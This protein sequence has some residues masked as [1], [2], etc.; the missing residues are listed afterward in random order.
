[1]PPCVRGR[2]G[3]PWDPGLGHLRHGRASL[4]RFAL[5]CFLCE[6]GGSGGISG[7][8]VPGCGGNGLE[9][10]APLPLSRSAPAAFLAQGIV[11]WM[12]IQAEKLQATYSKGR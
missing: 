3:S 10:P 4:Q 7:F 9:S 12:M 11:C 8:D 1:M 6:E 2:L 5:C